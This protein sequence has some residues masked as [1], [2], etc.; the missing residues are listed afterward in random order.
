MSQR[1]NIA[2]MI[3]KLLFDMLKI[4]KKENFQRCTFLIAYIKENNNNKTGFYVR[5]VVN[6]R[7]SS[8]WYGRLTVCKKTVHERPQIKKGVM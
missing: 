2:K 7:F 8:I 6:R 3:I 5:V 4:Q 1:S